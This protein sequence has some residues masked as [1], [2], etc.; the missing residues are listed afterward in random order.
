[1]FVMGARLLCANLIIAQIEASI[2]R[3]FF[4]LP[5][6]KLFGWMVAANYF[7]AIV[8]VILLEILGIVVSAR[9]QPMVFHL[10]GYLMTMFVIAM[11]LSFVLELPFV[12][13][14]LRKEPGT[15]RRSVFA[16]AAAQLGSYAV[17]FPIYFM[18]TRVRLASNVKPVDSLEF[19]TEKSA[20]ILFLSP[21]RR[22]V[23]RKRLDGS[24]SRKLLE[25]GDP[26]PS[27]WRRNLTIVKASDAQRCDLWLTES[28]NYHLANGTGSDR[29]L[30]EGITQHYPQRDYNTLSEAV[31]WRPV[32]ARQWSVDT[33]SNA[34]APHLGL[35]ADNAATG[36]AI[37]FVV[38][39]P[40]T[41]LLSGCPTF[42]PGG[43]LVFE[44]SGQILVL[45]LKTRKLA[46]VA[47][48][49]SPVVV[50]EGAQ[51]N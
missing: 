51:G 1:M 42:L 18:V 3:R 30:R 16:C 36:E 2:L 27:E 11:V 20:A 32:I 23:Y 19:V 14:A 15:M 17:L 35:K 22:S 46:L 34:Y 41:T 37:Q 39:T 21:D 4:K 31:D 49:H 24:Q 50:L 43:Q 5:R 40:F 28:W 48:G 38:D 10:R 26:T 6:L 13:A 9:F 45:D 8:G 29:L 12:I 44:M 7:S 47:Y 33:A 25:I